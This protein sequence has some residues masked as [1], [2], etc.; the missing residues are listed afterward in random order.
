MK[1]AFALFVTVAIV[2]GFFAQRAFARRMRPY[3]ER[4]CAGR[5]WR[6][7]FP[8]AAK[9]EIRDFLHLFVSSF[10]LDTKKKLTF[11][12]DDSV[13]TIYRVIYPNEGGADA[14]ECETFVA[15]CQKRYSVDLTSRWSDALTL[16]QI[17]AATHNDA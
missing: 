15:E 2:A 5:L 14:L 16:G 6:K 11:S 3:Y 7:R 12:P 1:F 9:S 4:N 10:G 8:D 13:V 17:F